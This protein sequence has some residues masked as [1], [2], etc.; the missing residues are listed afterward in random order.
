VDKHKLAAIIQKVDAL[1]VQFSTRDHF[2]SQVRAVRNGDFDHIAP[3]IFPEEWPRPVCANIVDNMARDFA[4][5]LSP[6]P[7]FTCSAASSLSDSARKFAEKRT[8]I[9]NFYVDSSKLKAQMP[10]AADSYNC[11]GMVVFSVEPDMESK[12]PKI[13]CEDGANV[14][15]VWDRNMRTVAAAKVY[16]LYKSQ[17]LAMYPHLESMF[18]AKPG[19]LIDG[20]KVKVIKWVDK[21]DCVVYLPDLGQEVV[22]EYKNPIGRCTVVAVPRPSGIGTYG[23]FIRGQYD[24]L[25]W[26]QIARNEFQILALEAADKA[27]RAPIIV[28]P[29]VTDVTFGPDAVMQTQNPQGVQRLKVDVP[30]ASFQAMEWLRSDMQIGGMS[31]EG[32]S[33]SVNASVIT[34]AGIDALNE[35]YSTQLAQAQEMMAFA[36]EQVIDLC[37]TVDEKVWPNLKKQIRGQET[38]VPYEVT[39][40]PS[41]DIA[42]DHSIDIQYGFLAGLDANR[43][44][45]F[46]LQ[47]YGAGLISQDYA[48]RNLPAH[49]NIS[50]E[51]KKIELEKVRKAIL[52]GAMMTA[53]AIPMMATQGGD[54][55]MLMQQLSSLADALKKGEA[56]ESAA[57]KAF[58]PPPPPPAPPGSEVAPGVPPSAPGAAAPP[59]SEAAG[60]GPPSDIGASQPGL[61]QLMAGITNGGASNLQANVLRQT[62][63]V[64]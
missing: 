21:D 52:E 57:L 48:M 39:Y 30:P 38:G 11:Y 29:D 42:G 34:G 63:T 62:P 47:A 37:F 5:K 53:Q 26:P 58:A 13:R 27:V 7:A 64:A 45:I 18:K 19:A 20:E 17:L 35:G 43:S 46:I 4:A 61:M 50:E 51:T 9:A 54:P 8:K 24:D 33:G 49:F 6:L 55:S 40:T 60:G 2:S 10:D 25:V 14:Y 28:P 32:R 44:L 59:G 56:V 3:G 16:L 41:K 12:T 36:L 23:A 1:Q 15:P 31:P 22:E